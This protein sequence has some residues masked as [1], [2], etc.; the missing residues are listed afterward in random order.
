[1]YRKYSADSAEN[2]GPA[3]PPSFLGDILMILVREEHRFESTL[4][5]GL[6]LK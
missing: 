6:T 3:L 1:M 4:F 5:T 2:K